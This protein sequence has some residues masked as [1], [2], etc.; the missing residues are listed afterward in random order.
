MVDPNGHPP[1]PDRPPLLTPERI[2][3]LV[4]DRLMGF[5]SPEAVAVG[6][7]LISIDPGS[8]RLA[9]RYEARVQTLMEHSEDPIERYLRLT[10]R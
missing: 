5:A 4:V 7:L 1:L 6:H 8:V 9:R 10:D 2:A 3:E